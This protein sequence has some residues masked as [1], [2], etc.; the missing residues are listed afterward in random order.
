MKLEVSKSLHPLVKV[1]KG[2]N[3]S[4]NSA[5]YPY[6]EQAKSYTSLAKRL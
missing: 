5:V 6:F 2:L 4:K 1:K 3:Q